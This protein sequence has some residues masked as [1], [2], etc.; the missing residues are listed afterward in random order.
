MNDQK[1]PHNTFLLGDRT[2]DFVKK[3]VQVILPATSALYF[4]LASIWDLPNP[5]KVVGTIAVLTTFLGVCLGISSAQYS[6]SDLGYDGNLVIKEPEEGKKIFSLEFD[7]DP[8]EIV[9]KK[10][11]SFKVNT[12]TP[13]VEATPR[14]VDTDPL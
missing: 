13:V 10:A 6:A 4:G 9:H 8:E 3:L 14:I 11:I 12:E 7:G 1:K 2:Y 5:D